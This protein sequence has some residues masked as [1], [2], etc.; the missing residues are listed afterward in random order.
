MPKK[1]AAFEEIRRKIVP[2][3]KKHN[4]TR[5]GI[6]GSYARGEQTKESD[7][8]ILVTPHWNRVWIRGNS[9]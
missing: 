8:D 9:V 3:L 6:F 4:V 1:T 7:V 2:V 5:A